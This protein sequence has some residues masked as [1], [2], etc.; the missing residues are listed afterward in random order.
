MGLSYF[1][2]FADSCVKS[3]E[4]LLLKLF[5]KRSALLDDL[6]WCT[7]SLNKVG[8]T[9]SIEHPLIQTENIRLGERK[10]QVFEHLG[11]VETARAQNRLARLQRKE[12]MKYFLCLANTHVQTRLT[13]FPPPGAFTSEISAYGI[14]AERFVSNAS[15][16]S[17]SY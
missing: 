8:V 1:P 7:F 14:A 12:P 2:F 15:K 17:Q 11:K 16:I 5:S 9:L 6:R 13:N 4:K 10:V 3:N